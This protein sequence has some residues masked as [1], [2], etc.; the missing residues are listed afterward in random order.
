MARQDGEDEDG[1]KGGYVEGSW[2]KSCAHLGAV[3]EKFGSQ[4]GMLAC[5]AN[6]HTVAESHA[7]LVTVVRTPVTLCHQSK[8]ALCVRFLLPTA[9]GAG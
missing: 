9:S 5:G 4:T 7:T 2:I 8:P 1:P 6:T 3:G